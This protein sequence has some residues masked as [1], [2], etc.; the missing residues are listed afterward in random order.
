MDD[1]GRVCSRISLRMKVVEDVIGFVW[2]MK[3]RRE[4]DSNPRN[5]SRF[6]GFQDHRHRPLGHPSASKLR[7]NSCGSLAYRRRWGAMCHPWVTVTPV[8][9]ELDDSIS[10][11]TWHPRGNRADPPKLRGPRGC[12]GAPLQGPV[13]WAVGAHGD[14]V[15]VTEG[16]WKWRNGR[17]TS[18]RRFL[19]AVS[20]STAWP[21]PLTCRRTCGRADR[22]GPAR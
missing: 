5:R 11:P 3:W 7:Q 16:I 15:F 1:S 22:L 20:W 19:A 4:R 2:T 13:V 14:R 8:R 6:S 9:H 12:Q 10:R 21:E 18:L 17:H